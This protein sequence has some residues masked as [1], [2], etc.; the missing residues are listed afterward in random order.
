MVA[1]DNLVDLLVTCVRHPAAAN[2]TFLVSDG[3]DLSTT[4]LLR[5]AAQALGRPARLLPVPTPALR[6][7]AWALG[8]G[9]V[10]QRLLGT[11]QVDVGKTR[12]LLGWAPVVTVDE[13]LRRTAARYLVDLQRA[14]HVAPNDGE[15]PR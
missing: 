7:A 2:Q 4:A 8:K 15:A 6:A 11:L 14:G 3:D 13:G 10:A 5:R 9:S 12:A 1:L